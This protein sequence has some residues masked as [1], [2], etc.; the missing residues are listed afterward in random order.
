[1]LKKAKRYILDPYYS[2][3]NTL[4]NHFPRL[5]T[6]R[7]YLSVFWKKCMGYEIDWD[8]PVTFNEKLQWLKLHDRQPIYTTMADK[9]KAKQWAAERIGQ[10][11]IIPTLRQYKT[12][13]EI[14][15]DLLPEQFVLKCNHDSGSVAICKDKKTFDLDAAKRKLSESLKNNF[16]WM[17]REWPYK[18]IKPVVFA[19]QYI[20]DTTPTDQPPHTEDP[21]TNIISTNLPLFKWHKERQ[22]C[23]GWPLIEEKITQAIELPAP[24][25]TIAQIAQ[26]YKNLDR[27]IGPLTCQLFLI[28][29]REYLAD[30]EIPQTITPSL[31]ASITSALKSPKQL[32]Q[33][34]NDKTGNTD[35]ILI[36]DDYIIHLH[37]VKRQQLFSGLRDYK[38][39]C[40]GGEP[41][42]IYIANDS[43]E[44]PTTNYFDMDFKPLPLY[45]RDPP[46]WTL[47]PKPAR[48]DQMKHLAALL[49]EG[50]PH[51]R[52]DFYDTTQALLF[53]EMTFYHMGGFSPIR[54]PEWNL[55]M[56]NW[57]KLPQ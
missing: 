33:L 2:F 56:G 20:Q 39:F 18:N 57:I 30:I 38:L 46:A 4:F 24:A 19:E 34:V 31:L 16:Y 49:S 8:H 51:V 47:P 26:Q 10:Q 48:F 15:L 22:Y 6:D 23:N 53:G 52:V 14:N 9:L 37:T 21:T 44:Y 5:M 55:Q 41:K 7:Y 45:S 11:H 13:D 25:S 3:G 29:G 27:A 43:A 32:L 35:A 1:M 28:D 40:F 12:V 50:I 17:A 36:E 42:I 54:P